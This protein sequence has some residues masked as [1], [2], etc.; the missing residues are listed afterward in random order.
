VLVHRGGVECDAWKEG[1]KEEE[2]QSCE[3][4]RRILK[5]KAGNIL[6]EAPVASLPPGGKR[7]PTARPNMAASFSQQP[8]SQVSQVIQFVDY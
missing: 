4:Q 2:V 5:E 8:S 3:G 1:R 6:T 7:G